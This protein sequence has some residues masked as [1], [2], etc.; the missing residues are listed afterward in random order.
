MTDCSNVK[1]QLKRFLRVFVTSLSRSCLDTSGKKFDINLFIKRYPILKEF[2]R[3][4]QEFE[5][6]TLKAVQALDHRLKHIPGY[7]N[8]I[9]CVL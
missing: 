4:D 6:E 2:I 5:L 1:L 9:I 8:L 7:S 3:N